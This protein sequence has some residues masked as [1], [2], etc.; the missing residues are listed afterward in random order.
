MVGSSIK[1]KIMIIPTFLFFQMS[2]TKSDCKKLRGMVL[3][4]VL[5]RMHQEKVDTKG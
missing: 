3:R 2:N 5:P 4:L 1:V